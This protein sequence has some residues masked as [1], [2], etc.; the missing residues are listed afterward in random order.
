[1]DLLCLLMLLTF[2]R[3]HRTTMATTKR[4][5]KYKFPTTMKSNIKHKLNHAR[6]SWDIIDKLMETLKNKNYKETE[7][8]SSHL[9][10]NDRKNKSSIAENISNMKHNSSSKSFNLL[11]T[12]CFLTIDLVFYRLKRTLLIPTYSTY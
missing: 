2:H 10:T 3:N 9:N 6:D 5:T 1:M 11:I 8:N 4:F 12:S 7:D